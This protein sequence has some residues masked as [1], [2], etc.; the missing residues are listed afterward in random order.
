MTYTWDFGDGSVSTDTN[1]IHT[2]TAAGSYDV[3]LTAM[4]CGKQ[5]QVTIEVLVGGVGLNTNI[6]SEFRIFPN[7]ISHFSRT[8][9]T[10]D[11]DCTA[12]IFFLHFQ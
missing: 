5:H 3:I 8:S 7:L 1:P 11:K 4:Y 2:Y 12:V 10:N 9:N 6:N